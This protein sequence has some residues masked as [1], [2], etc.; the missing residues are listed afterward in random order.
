MP[1]S[2]VTKSFQNWRDV[3]PQKWQPRIL[4]GNFGTRSAVI[5]TPTQVLLLM[6]LVSGDSID[7]KIPH[8][9]KFYYIFFFHISSRKERYALPCPGFRCM[10]ETNSNHAFPSILASGS[11]TSR[12][13]GKSNPPTIFRPSHLV[14]PTSPEPDLQAGRLFRRKKLDSHSHP[15]RSRPGG[16]EAGVLPTNHIHILVRLNSYHSVRLTNAR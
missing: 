6:P 12:A 9:S 11:S 7:D 3:G 4:R 16:G 14:I 8:R 13:G 5:L 10:T 1:F 15:P 2:N